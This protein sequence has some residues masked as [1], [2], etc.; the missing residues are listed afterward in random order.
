M[1]ISRSHFAVA[2]VDDIIYAFGGQPALIVDKYDPAT[3]TWTPVSG[4]TNG[5]EGFIAAIVG[6]EVYLIGGYSDVA[7]SALDWVE[8]YDPVADSFVGRTAMPTAR[9]SLSGLAAGN[10]IWAIGGWSGGGSMHAGQ[11]D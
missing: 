4:S 2:V 1:R 7:G 5:R 6:G 9:G 11:Q 10:L 8:E 3:D